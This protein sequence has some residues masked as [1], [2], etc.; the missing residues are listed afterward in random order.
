MQLPPD[1]SVSLDRSHGAG[2]AAGPTG[3]PT[4]VLDVL[5]CVR[6]LAVA[7]RIV[8]ERLADPGVRVRLGR[9]GARWA[10][11]LQALERT[12]EG[13]PPAASL[14]MGARRVHHGL[15]SVIGVGGVGADLCLLLE[16]DV[17][18]ARLQARVDG[19]LARGAAPGLHD[20]LRTLSALAREIRAEYELYA[21]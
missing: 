8:Q 4:A 20:T 10:D 5:A 9:I 12:L 19:L 17:L 7:S 21:A 14:A 2:L 18:A 16:L 11:A 15:R 3:V 13:E 6:S 1:S